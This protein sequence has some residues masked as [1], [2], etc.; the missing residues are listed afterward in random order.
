MALKVSFPS[1][2]WSK[3]GFKA[4]FEHLPGI[5]I[6]YPPN[7]T[8]DIVTKGAKHSPEFV[9]LPFKVTLGEF[10]NM[11]ELYKVDVFI[12]SIDC[13]P[14]RLGFYA[15]VQ[16]RILHDLGY[17]AKIIPIQQADLLNFEWLNPLFE[18][19]NVKGKFMRLI[20]ISA[21]IRYSF[22]KI[23]YIEDIVRLEGLIRCR[24]KTKG[25]TTKIVE[26]LM[27]K[28]NYENNLTNLHTFD[29]III[30]EFKKIPIKR[31]IEP[32][33]IMIAGENH[34]T[35][36]NFI[37]M[38]IMKK[39]GEEGIEVHYGNSLYD[40]VLHKLHINFK[41]KNLERLAKPYIPLDI[42]GEAIWVMGNYIEC[43]NNGFDGFIHTYPFTCM[44]EVSARGIIEGQSP[45]PFYLPIQFYAFDEH[46]GYEGMRTR[47]EAFIDLMKSNRKNNL[48][49]Q[50]NYQ[51]PK[52]I[53]EIYD[54]E[55]KYYGFNNF[56]ANFFNPACELLS[57]ASFK[58]EP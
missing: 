39:F 18:L 46:T 14:C 30:K 27:N 28:L 17:D 16:E 52:D 3:I 38:D 55:D 2:G 20:D 1:M 8:Q 44:P 42:G 26:K 22:T 29:R 45:D 48:K 12:M 21:G 41:R 15:P 57:M 7:V 10:I 49:F 37:N 36:E 24:E 53:E 23:G 9:C 43:Q 40:W 51:E 25:D 33:R 58:K 4:L 32:L 31:E 47:L 35:L 56:I 6:V 19:T 54:S 50:G 34:V 5:E 13:G 11:I